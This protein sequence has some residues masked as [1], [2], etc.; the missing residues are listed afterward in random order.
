MPDHDPLA[1]AFDAVVPQTQVKRREWEAWARRILAA[2][3]AAT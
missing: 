1:D 3:D 2:L